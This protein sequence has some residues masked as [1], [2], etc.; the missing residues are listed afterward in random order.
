MKC[1]LLVDQTVDTQQPTPRIS[2]FYAVFRVSICPADFDSGWRLY[3]KTRNP[4]ICEGLRVFQFNSLIGF[5]DQIDLPSSYALFSSS[6]P[7]I[8]P[9]CVTCPQ[10]TLPRLVQPICFS[11]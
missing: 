1:Y 9:G 4:L 6:L 8:S 10:S 5:S 2:P 11:R 3:A 7:S